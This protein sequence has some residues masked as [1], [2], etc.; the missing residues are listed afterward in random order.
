M[1]KT[2]EQ[3]QQEPG[4]STTDVSDL[5]GVS[6][7]QMDYW[8]RTGLICPSVHPAHGSGS[9]RRFSEEDFRQVR[10]VKAM[11]DAGWS[12]Q[13]VREVIE[14]V[15][16]E[17]LSTGRMIAVASTGSVYLFD[18]DAEFDVTDRLQISNASLWI[19][20]V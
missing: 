16:K 17:A 20:R 5:T 2:R 4:Y 3:M 1:P 18:Q 14:F 8:I 11:L 9:R 7:R 13:K 19:Y 15:P 12:L 6:Y 10:L